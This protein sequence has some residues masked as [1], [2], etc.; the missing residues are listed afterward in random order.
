MLVFLLILLGS[1]VVLVAIFYLAD[2]CS[3]VFEYC[4]EDAVRLSFDQFITFYKS[5]PNKLIL[6][7]EYV[8]YIGI[9]PERGFM[10]DEAEP[11]FFRNYHSLRKYRKWRERNKEVQMEGERNRKTLSL[12]KCWARD[13][14]EA[15][16][17]AIKGI[18]EL[19]SE[20]ESAP[21]PYEQELRNLMRRY[22]G[23]GH[24]MSLWGTDD[25][26]VHFS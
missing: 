26:E 3:F 5:A 16:A 2:F 10:Y 4:E 9:R 6:E 7:D 12:S 8:K 21:K 19:M 1:I 24:N 25:E 18:R 14:N 15:Y 17:N 20:N 13:V 11:V 22:D 23:I